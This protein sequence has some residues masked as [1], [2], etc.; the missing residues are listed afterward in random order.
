MSAVAR[1][2]GFDP[3]QVFAWRRKAL[4][5]GM[6]IDRDGA[7]D[8]RFVND[9]LLLGLK[10]TTLEDE[11]R[12]LR[13]RGIAAR[14]SKVRR[15]EYRFMLPPGFCWMNSSRSKSIAMN[16]W[17][18]WFNSASRNAASAALGRSFF[19]CA[20]PTPNACDP[21]NVQIYKLSWKAPAYR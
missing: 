11:L 7:Y 12:L 6:V 21:E 1:A 9:R 10:G 19:G 15:G 8:P 16:M 2:H 5:S 13:Q 17:R 3:S 20:P 14:D 4:A 18:E